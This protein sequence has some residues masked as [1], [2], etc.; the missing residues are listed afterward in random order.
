MSYT[1]KQRAEFVG[2]L[3]HIEITLME[4]LAAWVPT[5][6][7]MEV[8]V[9]FGRHIWETA[10]HADLLGRRT[11]ELRA[12]MHLTLAPSNEYAAFLRDVAAVTA[13]SQ[14]LSAFYDVVL[15]GITARLEAYNRET[16]HLLDEPTVRITRRIIHDNATMIDESRRLRGE[17]P[18]TARIDAAWRDELAA[19]ERAI[20]SLVAAREQ[21]Y[22]EVS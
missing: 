21:S 8:K 10:Q 22:A 18:A 9:L 11:Y 13:T 12:P 6:P 19:R 15:P 17:L 14:R 4:T 7:E 5:T 3:R 2:T 1:V 20:E 16:D